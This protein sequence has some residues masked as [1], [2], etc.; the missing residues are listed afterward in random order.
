MKI[1]VLTLFDDAYADFINSSIIKRAIE[2]KLVTIEIVDFRQYSQLKHKQVDDY[3]FGGG[4]GMVI[5]LPPIVSAIKNCKRS[6]SHIVLTSPSGKLLTQKELLTLS[7]YEHL[8]LIAG[9]YE[10]FDCRLENY[11]DESISIGDYILTGGELPTMVIM[12]ALI[13]LI[14]GAINQDSLIDESFNNDLLD[15]PAYTKPLEFEGHKVPE[16]LL[17]G[18]HQLIKDFRILQQHQITKKN[19]PDLYQKHLQK[20]SKNG[21]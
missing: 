18:N 6:D 2:K 7:K 8:I 10:G 13:R 15:Y 1:T 19:R 14:P 9:H 17:S 3:Q 11:I 12:D 5:S 16:V 21:N 4:P 20:G